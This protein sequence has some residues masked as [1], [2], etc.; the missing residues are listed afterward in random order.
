ME[1]SVKMDVKELTA[2]FNAAP[3]AVA[4]ATA[5]AMNRTIGPARTAM[6]R[7]IRARR[8]LV[9]MKAADIKA[10]LV[11]HHA[12]PYKLTASVQI[13]GKKLPL[14]MYRVKRSKKNGVSADVVGG[15]Y[16]GPIMQ[17]SNK[18]F[19]NIALGGGVP[20]FVRKT[21]ER[22]PISKLYGP[23]LP[24]AITAQGYES[25][26][27]VDMQAAWLKN[28]QRALEYRLGQLARA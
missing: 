9:N 10:L 21:V 13:S 24:S 20:I 12:T 15:G 1:L 2:M 3:K 16:K 7:R 25:V 26:L 17:Y 23:S 5:D 19:T 8:M 27:L 4:Q 6:A 11:I 14:E 18:A 22:L 28:I